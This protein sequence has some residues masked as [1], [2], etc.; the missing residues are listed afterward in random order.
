MHQRRTG[1]NYWLTLLTQ[2]NNKLCDEQLGFDAV[3]WTVVSKELKLEEIQEDIGEKIGLCD[4]Q[5]KNKTLRE[6]A[7]EILKVLSRKKGFAVR[8]MLMSTRVE[9]LGHDEAWELFQ[10]NLQGVVFD[11]NPDII[12][13]A[14]KVADECGGLP[15]VIKIIAQATACNTTSEELD[16]AIK[17]LKRSPS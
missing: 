16:Y 9:C 12:E 2:I 6:K 3:I 14:K 5:W 1:L 10:K 8:C 11:C 17:V 4:V 13:L 7:Q 15:L